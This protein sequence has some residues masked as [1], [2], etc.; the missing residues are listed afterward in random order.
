MI[1]EEDIIRLSDVERS[2]VLNNNGK[3]G[4]YRDGNNKYNMKWN[5][6]PYI[7]NQI[8]AIINDDHFMD[9]NRKW[10][11]YH[12]WQAPPCIDDIPEIN[13]FLN[14][15][16][17]TDFDINKLITKWDKVINSDIGG[18]VPSKNIESLAMSLEI[19]T[20]FNKLSNIH[21]TD[22]YQQYAL[23]IIRRL[24]DNN[25][26]TCGEYQPSVLI[27]EKMNP[28]EFCK[29]LECCYTMG[30]DIENLYLES[31]IDILKA[32]ISKITKINGLLIIFTDT[33]F[34]VYA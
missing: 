21:T 17:N 32:K 22:I 19:Q 14:K 5:E 16:D 31:L 26:M 33:E 30:Q 3:L 2:K 1:K 15:I 24:Y 8:S 18:V 4:L 7:T 11:E 20:R 13:K 29:S 6:F 27:Q 28:V 10:G 34:I 25:A 23:P 9:T 12:K